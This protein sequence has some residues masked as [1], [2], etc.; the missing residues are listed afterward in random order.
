MPKSKIVPLFA[1]QCS[2][3]EKAL[4]RITE[5]SAA[6]YKTKK[7]RAPSIK[8]KL[9][10]IT[11]KANL[12]KL[13][14]GGVAKDHHIAAYG[15]SALGHGERT[16]ARHLNLHRNS[17]SDSIKYAIE[18]LK[19]KKTQRGTKRFFPA[20]GYTTLEAMQAHLEELSTAIHARIKS[21]PKKA[22]RPFTL[23]EFQQLVMETAKLHFNGLQYNR[24]AIIN[25]VAEHETVKPLG[26]TREQLETKVK[27]AL[28]LLT[29]NGLLPKSS[30]KKVSRL[31]TATAEQIRTYS[32]LINRVL[33]QQWFVYPPARHWR[34]LG[35]DE[36]EQIAR[37]G[38]IDGIETYRGQMEE[39]PQ[40]FTKRLRYKIISRLA[41]AVEIELHRKKRTA[42]FDD[43]KDHTTDESQTQN[44]DEEQL[45]QLFKWHRKGILAAHETAITALRR[46]YG[47]KAREVGA[48]FGINRTSVSQ[49][50]TKVRI[51]LKAAA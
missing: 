19:N 6:L 16:I 51:K 14:D 3:L 48:H 49:I 23:S 32:P 13:I 21:K 44:I 42:S 9:D 7:R 18:V 15:L 11:L 2:T 41:N 45:K 27:N 37:R 25:I 38:L 26:R 36:A 29:K 30:S 5:I 40:R 33:R 39:N 35:I 17:V 43:T 50:E 1:G 24:A 12:T 28:K 8:P 31:R 4:G 46:V 47:Y 22:E 34:I 10:R 20:K